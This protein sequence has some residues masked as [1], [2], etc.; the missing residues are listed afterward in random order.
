[1]ILNLK[2]SYLLLPIAQEYPN[3]CVELLSAQPVFAAGTV[4]VG[5]AQTGTTAHSVTAGSCTATAGSSSSGAVRGGLVVTTVVGSGSRHRGD[6][7]RRGS[8]V[9]TAT[10]KRGDL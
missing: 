4:L 7:V 9:T 1:M 10:T 8:A 3:G 5:T 2:F 6:F